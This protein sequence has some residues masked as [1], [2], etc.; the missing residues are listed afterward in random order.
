MNILALVITFFMT[1]LNNRA[2]NSEIISK[3]YTTPEWAADAIK[4][5]ANPA[6]KGIIEAFRKSITR[7][8]KLAVGAALMTAEIVV[9]SAV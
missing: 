8:T 4:E 6:D 7:Y 2:Q 5:G 3:E 9:S 1:G